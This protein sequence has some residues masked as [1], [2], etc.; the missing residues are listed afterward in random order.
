L[1]NA[2]VDW[3][4]DIHS[5]KAQWERKGIDVRFL[6]GGAEMIGELKIA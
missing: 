2:F 6:F 5:I 3:L 4:K 1:A